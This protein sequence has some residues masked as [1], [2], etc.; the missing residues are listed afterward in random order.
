MSDCIPCKLGPTPLPLSG[1]DCGI[2]DTN[3]IDST[4]NCALDI[5]GNPIVTPTATATGACTTINGIICPTTTTCSPWDLS[6]ESSDSCV[7][8]SYVQESINIGGAPLNVYKLLGVHEQGLLQDLTGNGN[9]ISNGDMPNFPAANAFDKHI[10]EWRSLQIGS[11]VLASAYVGYDFGNYKISNGRVRYGIETAVKQDI[12]MLKIKQGCDPLNRVTKVRIERSND[13][14]KWFGVTVLTLPDCDGLI[15]LNFA[16][17]VPSRYWRVRPITFNGGSDDYWVIQALQLID[18]EVTNI[19]N[20]QDRIFL[21]NR[22]RD[23]D[24]IPIK[25]KASYT[26]IDVVSNSTKFGFFQG[27]TDRYIINVSF[28]Q[29]IISLGRPFVI[30]DIVELPSETQYTPTLSPVKKY[31]EITDV[32][33]AVTGFTANWVPTLQR[34]IAQPALASQETQNIFGNL[35]EKIDTTGL[36]DIDDGNNKIYQDYSAISSTIS[37]TANSNDPERGEDDADVTKFSDAVNDFAK[38]HPNM[39]FKKFDRPHDGYGID[40]MPPNGLPFTED[41]KF[42]SNPKDGDYHRLS[43]TKV[44]KDIP[45]RLY[46]YSSKKL[47]WVYLETDRRYEF[48]NTK[49]YLQEYLNPD[50]SSVTPLN[51]EFKPKS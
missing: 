44:G 14:Q 20:I 4:G 2:T 43:Y 26:P 8:N 11:A 15:T 37:A 6:Q 50:T 35:T 39:N 22:D 49:P 21:E 40:A 28:T 41:D 10:T 24:N 5:N 34:L 25:M 31:L 16:H 45:T 27:D 18:Y 51:Q 1:A 29:A 19:K 3:P 42:P 48:N 9:A 13:G 33:W 30:G 36:V 23:Y 32:A 46:R 47:Y 12:A 17:S 38:A 7:V